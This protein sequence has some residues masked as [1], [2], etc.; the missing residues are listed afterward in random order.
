M[1]KGKIEKTVTIEQ[2]EFIKAKPFEVYDAF[3]DP[4]RHSEFTGAEATGEPKVGGEFTAWDG[5]ISG[6]HLKLENGKRILQE[7][8]TTEWPDGRA[9]SL[10][11]LAFE[12]K[13]DGTQVTLTHSKVP[14]E[15]AEEYRQGW[16]DF[17]W[18]PLKKYFEKKK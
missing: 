11:E 2:A 16:I 15:Q 7:W 12:A 1:K 8:V 5:Y 14:A 6:K 18:K 9:S 3:T 13:G 4:K 17:Y 10:L